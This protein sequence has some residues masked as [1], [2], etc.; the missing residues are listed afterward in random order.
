MISH[1]IFAC[2][3]CWKE[4]AFL[5]TTGR[6]WMSLNDIMQACNHTHTNTHAHTCTHS[7]LNWNYC[8]HL[9]PRLLRFFNSWY[10]NHDLKN[11]LSHKP[12]NTDSC[13]CIF[14]H[15]KF[16]NDRALLIRSTEK[17]FISSTLRDRSK[18]APAPL[19]SH[20]KPWVVVSSLTSAG[21]TLPGSEPFLPWAFCLFS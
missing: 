1:H 4:G 20:R 10:S 6:T 17:A 18:K 19:G 9:S 5:A 11:I 8:N 15:L 12:L 7:S 2:I 21:E 14:L 3:A 13:T 16:T